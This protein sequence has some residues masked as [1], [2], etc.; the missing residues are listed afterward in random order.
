MWSDGPHPPSGGCCPARSVWGSESLSGLR[1]CFRDMHGA[2]RTGHGAVAA[3]QGGRRGLE[4]LALQLTSTDGLHWLYPFKDL[5]S[6]ACPVSAFYP[7]ELRV[8]GPGGRASIQVA[9]PSLPLPAPSPLHLLGPLN[10]SPLSESQPVRQWTATAHY[11]LRWPAPM[12]REGTGQVV[13]RIA[14]DFWA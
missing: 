11:A 6:R 10:P 14:A 7:H 2:P 8:G 13:V 4:P 3:Q 1:C 12:C 9:S 5:R